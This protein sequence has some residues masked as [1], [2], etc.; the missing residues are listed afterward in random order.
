MDLESKYIHAP[1]LY[2][3]HWLN[4]EPVSLHERS[5]EVVL[6]DFWDYTSINCIR[7]LPYIQ[8]WHR[9]YQEFGLTVVGVHTPVFD[10][11]G[12]LERVQTAVE[13]FKVEYPVMLDN[14]A[15][16]WSAYNIH[17][18][19]T[20]CLV[21]RDGFIRYMQHGEGGYLEFERALQQLLIEA[22]C[23]RELPPLCC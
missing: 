8:E 23:H 2:G 22:G 10:F 9:K 12:S 4:A 7:A 20:R 1:E 15:K 11:A 17:F 21:D 19:P 6:I 18:W 5:G 3:N 14:E 16:M 13:H